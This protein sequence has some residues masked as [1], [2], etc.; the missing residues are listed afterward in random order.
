MLILFS[1]MWNWEKFQGEIFDVNCFHNYPGLLVMACLYFVRL[2]WLYLFIGFCWKWRSAK[3]LL[4]NND[5][6]LVLINFLLS[7]DGQLTE[8][9]KTFRSMINAWNTERS[10]KE[11]EIQTS[12]FKTTCCIGESGGQGETHHSHFKWS[13]FESLDR[14][15]R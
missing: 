11:K 7:V 2:V 9:K 14:Y 5:D 8:G 1:Y 13:S 10:L 3:V 4:H 12:W 15:L 6:S